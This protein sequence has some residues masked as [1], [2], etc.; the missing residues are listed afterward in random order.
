[1]KTPLLVSSSLLGGL[2][3]LLAAAP[4][5]AQDSTPPPAAPPPMASSSSSSMGGGA[6]GVGAVVWLANPV[7]NINN[8]ITGGQFVYDMSA[9]HIEGVVGYVHQSQNGASASAFEVA[10]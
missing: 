8:P 5:K 1:M 4:A 3:L 2:V 9:F 7:G 6:I 10:Q